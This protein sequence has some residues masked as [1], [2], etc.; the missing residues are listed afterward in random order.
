MSLGQRCISLGKQNEK[1]EVVLDYL[2]AEN[3]C[4]SKDAIKQMERQT[5]QWENIFALGIIGKR[6]VSSIYDELQ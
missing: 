4:L 1:F 2:K 6:L 3:I 5:L